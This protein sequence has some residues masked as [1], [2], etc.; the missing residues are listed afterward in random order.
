MRSVT[1]SL[2]IEELAEWQ[3]SMIKGVV[4]SESDRHLADELSKGAERRLVIEEMR[5]GVRISAK[6]WVGV[7]RFSE[8]ELR[9][10]PKLVGGNIGLVEMIEFTS[11]LNALRRN[12]GTRT[13][14]ATG[15]GLLDLMAL[16]LAEQC[17]R[18]LRNGLLADY[19][20]HEDE[21]PVV[22]GRLLGDKQ[23]LHRIG[24]VDRVICRFDEHE[25]DVI[26]NQVLAAALR[27]VAHRIRHDS[28]RQRA[29]ALRGIFDVVCEPASL[30][31]DSARE[32]LSYNRL[33]EQYREAHQLAFLIL[34]AM[35]ADDL[36]APGATGCFA[37]LL[38]M[39]RLFERFVHRLVD[40][41]LAGTGA[42]VR[43][44]HVDNSIILNAMTGAPYKRVIPDLLIE[45][46]GPEPCC[47]AMDAKYKLYDDR[48]L[49]SGDVYQS[50]LYAHAYGGAAELKLPVSLL[51]Y[52][53]TG[54]ATDSVRLRIKGGQGVVGAEVVAL[55][56]PIAGA[57]AEVARGVRGA[58]TGNLRALVLQHLEPVA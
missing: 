38:D 9:I 28:V 11:G 44:Q 24:R 31:V 21:I 2:Q 39:N 33:N 55:S 40:I 15:A 17:E 54:A 30:D 1:A 45:T 8:F 56:L 52:P 3:V 22:R 16:L 5:A 12:S 37:F 26:E 49:S 6:S 46:S 53:T 18:I 19:V 25:Q 35:G 50:F 4:L 14:D 23:L 58:V 13:L 32:R 36:L 7:V 42:R 10:V 47:L 29:M 51:V 27:A 41:C 20:E 48:D 34:D 43:Y 57:L